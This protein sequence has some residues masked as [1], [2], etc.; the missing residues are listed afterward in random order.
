MIDVEK[1]HYPWRHL[2]NGQRYSNL[3]G[4]WSGLLPND[5]PW[6]A[7]PKIVDIALQRHLLEVGYVDTLLGRIIDQL[8]ANGVWDDSLI[9]VTADHGSAFQSRIPRRAAVPENMGEIASVPLFV[10]QPGQTEPE[11][12]AEHQCSTDTLPGIA[13]TLEIDYPWDLTDCPKN[14][15]TVINSPS[16]E[17][18]VS[19]DRMVYQRQRL[20][21]RIQRVFGTGVGFGPTYRS[22]PRR[23]LIGQRVSGLTLR[24]KPRGWRA[25]PVRPNSVK[26]YNPAAASLK[27]LLQRGYNDLIPENRVLAVAVDGVIQAT[28]WTFKDGLGYG[29]GFSILL[30]PDSLK[31]GFNQVDIYMLGD[32]GKKVQLV[33]DGSKPFT[34]GQ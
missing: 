15:A 26:H 6:M 21:N 12:V 22:G 1:P 28:G 5:G 16:G 30:P 33:H 10:K 4:E 2:P 3:T 24:A 14:Q 25:N 29:P 34:K 13:D 17:A 32:G 7:P 18:S 31:R 27:G 9:V 8:K 19:I 11:V 23:E 20:I